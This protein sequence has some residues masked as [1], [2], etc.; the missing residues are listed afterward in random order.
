[1]ERFGVSDDGEKIKKSTRAEPKS[2]RPVAVC[3]PTS[4]STG[5]SQN[6]NHHL[7]VGLKPFLVA[8]IICCA[9]PNSAGERLATGHCG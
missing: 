1:M 6:L 2:G 3:Q 5:S 7:P 9:A 8:E 4:A